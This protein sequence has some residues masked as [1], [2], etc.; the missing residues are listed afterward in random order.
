MMTAPVSWT[1]Y[2]GGRVLSL[3]PGWKTDGQM[4]SSPPAAPR[5]GAD[6]EAILGR[7]TD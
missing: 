3:G 2:P 7:L 1:E 6:T 4:P 5:L